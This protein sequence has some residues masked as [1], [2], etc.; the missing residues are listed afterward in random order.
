MADVI[1]SLD[2]LFPPFAE[3]VTKFNSQI[4]KYGF[5]PFETFRS[6]DRQ[7]SLWQQ[8]RT[9]QNGVWVV[10]DATK[11]VTK[12][13]PGST[14]HQYGCAVDEIPDADLSK[15]GIQWTWGDT[16][17][18]A[19]GKTIAVPWK[20]VGKISGSLGLDWGGNWAFVDLPHHQLLYGCTIAELYQ[21]LV[22]E[23]LEAVW[24]HLYTKVPKIQTMVSVPI[25]LQ[26][27]PVPPPPVVAAEDMGNHMGAPAGAKTGSIFSFLSS[28]FSRTGA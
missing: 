14:A 22:S 7:M 9:L 16:M 25:Q 2:A 27:K 6:F 12:A 3:Q 8:G 10:A 1:N 23:G 5:Y 18:D 20:T 21:L 26:A 15:Q 11:I 24:K 19:A 17:K 4:Q 28:L 13:K